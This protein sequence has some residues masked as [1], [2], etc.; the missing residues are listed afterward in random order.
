V[1][2]EAQ[3]VPPVAVASAEAGGQAMGPILSHGHS[4]RKETTGVGAG[5]SFRDFRVLCALGEV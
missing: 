4:Q 5:G 1:G 3:D 2:A